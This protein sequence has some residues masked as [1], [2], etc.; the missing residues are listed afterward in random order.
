M[1][2]RAS[3]DRRHHAQKPVKNI[4]VPQPIGPTV[5]FNPFRRRLFL[6]KGIVI[7]RAPL[8]SK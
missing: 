4:G 7:V 2:E 3:D 6:H 5:L 1:A 8:P